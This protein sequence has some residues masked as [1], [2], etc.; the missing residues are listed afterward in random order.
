M[1]AAYASNSVYADRQ[2]SATR[3]L[4]RVFHQIPRRV[5]K[6][7]PQGCDT[8]DGTK[9][10]GVSLGHTQVLHDPLAWSRVATRV[11][12][13]IHIM[14]SY[15]YRIDRHPNRL[16]GGWRLQLLENGVEIDSRLFPAVVDD[17]KAAQHAYMEALNTAK[18]WLATRGGTNAS[19]AEYPGLVNHPFR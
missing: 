8:A 15:S 18:R 4:R 16:G 9:C 3:M 6:P 7:H 14:Q 12:T 1:P 13:T 10:A 2:R 17:K 5:P 11:C 19:S